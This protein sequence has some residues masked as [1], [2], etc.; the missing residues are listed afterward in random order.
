MI[1]Q[2]APRK[3]SKEIKSTIPAP[4]VH[5]KRVNSKDTTA[6]APPP[7]ARKNSSGEY[8]RL[9]IKVVKIKELELP[10]PKGM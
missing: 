8:G 6:M 1:P 3:I 7:I 9:F 10:L 5:H 2:P 4:A